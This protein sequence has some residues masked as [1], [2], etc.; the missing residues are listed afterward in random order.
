MCASKDVES[1]PVICSAKQRIRTIIGLSPVPED[2]GHA[3]NTRLW[4]LRLEPDADVTLRLA[5][6]AHDIERARPD[7]LS[8]HD[9]DNYDDFKARHAELGAAIADTVLAQCK[10]D[11]DVRRTVRHLI[12]RHE[13]GGDPKSDLLKDADSLSF[14]DHNLPMY[15][16]REGWAE[17]LERARWGYQR[18]SR[19]AQYY[20]CEIEHHD[21]E[22]QQLLYEA[23]T[24]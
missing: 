13:H 8:R 12:S 18:L 11:M 21:P 16:Q 19:R 6:L 14:F 24:L 17:T 22:L 7:R 2:P 20:Y 3:E 1:D 10:V 4:V 23:T 15:Y 9:F 5:A